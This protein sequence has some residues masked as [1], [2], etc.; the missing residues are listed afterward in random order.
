MHGWDALVTD[1]KMK[2]P[3]GDVFENRTLELVDGPAS[4]TVTATWASTAPPKIMQA[5]DAIVDSITMRGPQAKD[6]TAPSVVPGSSAVVAGNATGA[7]GTTS[8]PPAVWKQEGVSKLVMVGT[9]LLAGLIETAAM[10][11]I[12][13]ALRRFRLISKNVLAAAIAG[14][15]VELVATLALDTGRGVTHVLWPGVF[16]IG[17]LHA[18]GVLWIGLAYLALTILTPVSPTPQSDRS[19]PP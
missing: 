13:W 5:C 1:A 8:R 9:F 11:A 3:T 16:W 12:G 19:A 2:T 6:V 4:I 7:S 14:V 18:P 10:I 17:Y 15:I